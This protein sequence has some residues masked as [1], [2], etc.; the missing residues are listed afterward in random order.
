MIKDYVYYTIHNKALLWTSNN[1]NLSLKIKK[2][3]TKWRLV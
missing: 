2:K 3:N 1:M